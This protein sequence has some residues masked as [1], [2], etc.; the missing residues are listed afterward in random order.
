MLNS[1]KGLFVSIFSPDGYET[2]RVAIHVAE[3]PSMEPG[4]Y[5]WLVPV[6]CTLDVPGEWKVRA[7]A[8]KLTLN[9]IAVLVTFPSQ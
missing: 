9:E 2:S 3:I 1:K 4:G 7:H 6:G 5:K 8:D